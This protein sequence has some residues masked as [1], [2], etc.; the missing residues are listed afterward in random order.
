MKRSVVRTFRS[1]YF[2]YESGRLVNHFFLCASSFFPRASPFRAGGGYGPDVPNFY[3]RSLVPVP[4]GAGC[5]GAHQVDS[6]R[7]AQSMR[8]HCWCKYEP[9]L[10]L[11]STSRTH[12]CLI[13]TP[14][15]PPPE[16]PSAELSA[17]GRQS[18]VEGLAIS[19]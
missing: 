9:G 16:S 13:D 14:C 4:G 3:P 1:S 7:R 6:V 5:P 10:R 15:G 12:P 19:P 2:F 11:V 8:T 18:C 17:G